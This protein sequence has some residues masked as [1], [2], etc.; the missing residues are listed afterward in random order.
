MDGIT[1]E[2]T[3][4]PMKPT[5]QI[6]VREIALIEQIEQITNGSKNP[7]DNQSPSTNKEFNLVKLAL[8]IGDVILKTSDTKSFLII[9]RKTIGDLLASIKDGRYKEQS[10]RLLNHCGTKSLPDTDTDTDTEEKSFHHHNVVYIIEGIMSSLA[11]NLKKQVYGAI[12]SLNYFKGF[13]VIRT[14]CVKE[15]AELIIHYTTKIDSDILKKKLNVHYHMT[16]L[17]E[18]GGTNPVHTAT[19]AE[20][21]VHKVKR[22]NITTENIATFMVSQIP[23]ISV[24]TAQEILKHFDNSLF[25]L[26]EA[27]RNNE[28]STLKSIQIQSVTG[29][30]RKISS[31]VVKDLERFLG[32]SSSSIDGTGKLLV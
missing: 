19:Y 8:P 22:D 23:G 5:I 3:E 24:P 25:K 32:N 2:S 11:S 20:A 16:R 28:L 7:A 1:I 14:S 6:D 12:A 9:E 26:Q 29:K 27:L 13:S 15:T 17:P 21:A 31:K 10:F 4:N 30:K 18:P